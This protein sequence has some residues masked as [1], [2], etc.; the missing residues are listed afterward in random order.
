MSVFFLFYHAVL[1]VL[2]HVYVQNSKILALKFVL[3]GLQKIIF[4]RH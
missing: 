4:S 2:Q 1:I 3:F